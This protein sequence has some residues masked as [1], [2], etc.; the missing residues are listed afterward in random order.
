MSDT[1]QE[2]GTGAPAPAE[3]PAVTPPS[4]GS[5][6]HR[7]AMIA[8]YDAQ[9]AKHEPAAATPPATQAQT[10]PPA[11][12]AATPPAV[13]KLTDPPADTPTAPGDTTQPGGETEGTAPSL[14]Y[15]AF[16]AG[17]SA[18]A[19][20]D[21]VA[22]AFAQQTGWSAEQVAEAHKQFLAGQ[23]ALAREQTRSLHEAAGGAEQFNALVAWGQKNLTSEQ[24]SF[25][26]RELNGPNA[27]DAIALLRQRMTAGSEPRLHQVN[28]TAAPQP[29][30]F[31]DKSEM[32]AAMLDKRYQTSEAYRADVAEKLRHSR[33]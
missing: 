16:T 5:P 24:R 6:E 22:Q 11:E 28:G 9:F 33:F 14:D 30:G 27:A 10:A 1:P 32:T 25:Y 7:A 4:P 19:L 31:R 3:T 21:T 26:D 20:D 17:F 15:D 13:P 18:E 29:V 12:P 8:A 23:Q 2:P